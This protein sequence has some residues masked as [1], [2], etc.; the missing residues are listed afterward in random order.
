MKRVLISMFMLFYMISH[1]QSGTEIFLF[2]IL[3]EGNQISISNPTNVSNHKG[4]DNQP[5]FHQTG[6]ILY[7]SSANSD[8]RSDIK[9]FNFETLKTQNLTLTN[10]REYSPT[11]TPD[12]NF[13]SCILQRDNGAQDLVKY[14]INGG[15]PIVLIQDLL[16]GYH[17]WIDNSRLIT[18]VLLEDKGELRYFDLNADKNT[19]ITTA[20]GR[21]LHQIPN[22]SNMSYIDKSVSDNWQ[23]TKFDPSTKKSSIIASTFKQQEDM[24]WTENH[25]ILMSDGSKIYFL[26][27]NAD[28][29]W[30]EVKTE[31]NFSNFKGITRMA[32]NKENTKLAIVVSE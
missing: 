3:V 29:G 8:G 15:R 28:D 2:D 24:V 5:S 13:I 4:Y 19:I 10:E 30:I 16:I 31:C 12:G 32:L 20:I 7:Y 22:E 27:P 6:P 11:Q 18:Y 25:L 1:S 9:Y 21:S 17:A 23:I 14:P 26:N